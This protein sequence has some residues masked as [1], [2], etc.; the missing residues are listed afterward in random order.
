MDAMQDKDGALKFT[1]RRANPDRRRF[2]RRESDRSGPDGSE[3]DREKYDSRET[4][5]ID[6]ATGEAGKTENGVIQAESDET[7][8]RV[9]RKS[10]V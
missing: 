3:T 8:R 4:D 10:V 9:D 6:F 1:E 2:S 5:K 7:I